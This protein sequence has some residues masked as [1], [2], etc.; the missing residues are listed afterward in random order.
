MRMI[1]YKCSRCG[2][3]IEEAETT[4]WKSLVYRDL[5]SDSDKVVNHLCRDCA[6]DYLSFMN[7]EAIAA[8][9]SGDDSSDED[10]TLTDDN[11]SDSTTIDDTTGTATV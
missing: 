7:G 10:D 2:A 6:T 11:G 4:D 9:G 8:V 5:L 3:L 1:M